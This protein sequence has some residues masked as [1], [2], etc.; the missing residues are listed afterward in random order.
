[1]HRRMFLRGSMGALALP[2]LESFGLPKG[3]GGA[4][5]R[6][7]DERVEEVGLHRQFLR[8]SCPALLSL[9]GGADPFSAQGPCSRPKTPQA[10]DPLF[11]FGSRRE[12]RA[13]CR[14]F[15]SFGSQAIAGGIH[16]ERKPFSGSKGCGSFGLQNPLPLLSRWLR[17]RASRGMPNVMDKKRRA[18]SP[19]EGPRELFR[20]L[21]LQDD[22]KNRKIVRQKF[23][24]K[25]SIWTPLWRTPKI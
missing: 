24:L 22:Q 11:P 2:A 7:A 15:L 9:Q 13:L 14:S 12:R 17:K 18:G 8:F 6:V 10:H 19:I 4:S 5:V 20:K 1:M 21:Y 25:K 16:A 3:Q 23:D